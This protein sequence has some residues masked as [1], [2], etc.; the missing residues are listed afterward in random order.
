MKILGKRPLASG[1]VFLSIS[2]QWGGRNGRLTT[3]EAD[4]LKILGTAVGQ[5]RGLSHLL[6]GLINVLESSRIAESGF[7]DLTVTQRWLEVS[8][9]SGQF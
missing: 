3:D 5:R 8:L 9:A 6:G 1:A 7:K 4:A 2:V